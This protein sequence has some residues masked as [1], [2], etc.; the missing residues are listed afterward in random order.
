MFS[1]YGIRR[2]N[3]NIYAAIILVRFHYDL[4][5]SCVGISTN[6]RP[7]QWPVEG[8]SAVQN[9]FCWPPTGPLWRAALSGRIW[10]GF[11]LLRGNKWRNQLNK[12]FFEG[13][14][15]VNGFKKTC[16]KLFIYP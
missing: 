14:T 9:W 8:S 6:H 13:A 10:K 2:T 3:D 12:V 5:P 4:P 11:W 7:C 15:L 1:W 16:S